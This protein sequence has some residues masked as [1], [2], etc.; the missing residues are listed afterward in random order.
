MYVHTSL[1]TFSF[2]TFDLHDIVVNLF[3]LWTPGRVAVRI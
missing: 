2:Q 1:D 3:P